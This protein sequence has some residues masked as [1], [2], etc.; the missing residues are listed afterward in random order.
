MLILNLLGTLYTYFGLN[1]L[2]TLAI[3]STYVYSM[4]LKSI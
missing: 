4:Q 3:T 1:Q 2:Y